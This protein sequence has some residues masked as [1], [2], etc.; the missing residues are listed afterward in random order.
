MI[1]INIKNYDIVIIGLH[2]F[3][4]TYVLDEVIILSG[5]YHLLF[6]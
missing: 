4:E 2:L 3:G 5:C 6:W 1:F